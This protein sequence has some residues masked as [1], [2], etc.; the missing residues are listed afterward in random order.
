MI[1]LEL[2]PLVLFTLKL[3]V[4][5]GL[6]F[7]G[8]EQRLFGLLQQRQVRL[9]NRSNT[10]QDLEVILYVRCSQIFAA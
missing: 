10:D 1:G 8:S 4:G 2:D 9:I 5:T 6:A 3:M 7:R